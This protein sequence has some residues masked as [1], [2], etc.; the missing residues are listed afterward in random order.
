EEYFIIADQRLDD[1]EFLKPSGELRNRE[2][3]R[4]LYHGGAR[5]RSIFERN[6]SNYQKA[7]LHR[8]G[9][10]H[11]RFFST[12]LKALSFKPIQSVREFVYDN[13]LDRRELQLD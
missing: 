6:K 2:E 7:L 1:L 10:L 8:M 3:F 12:F 5:V 9:S 4:R 11:E 13:I